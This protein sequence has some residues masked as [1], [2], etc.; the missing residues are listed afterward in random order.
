M[1]TQT[2]GPEYTQ[3]QS[4]FVPP[5]PST[6][7]PPKK[8]GMSGWAIALIVIGVVILVLCGGG[9]ALIGLV[10]KGISDS[11]NAAKK[12]VSLSSCSADQ[13]QYDLVGPKA[14]VDV[15][16]HG[17]RK[18]TYSVTVEFVSSDGGT[19]IGTGVAVVNDL[20]AGQSA[21]ADAVSFKGGQ[22]SNAFK[23]NITKVS[24]F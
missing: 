2:P 17:T 19:Q 6:A 22:G 8:K 11:Q 7:Y 21:Q 9:V 14:V 20:Q 23:C 15:T 13:S 12:D 10:G 4:P 24:K 16:N 18:A 1:T 3:P 5:F